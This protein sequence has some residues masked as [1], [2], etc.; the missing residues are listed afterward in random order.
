MGFN[1]AL[2]VLCD[3]LDEIERDPEFGKKVAAAIREHGS[4]AKYRRT[5]ITGQTQ[6]ISVDHADARQIIE[7]GGNTG[8]IV[9][10]GL[11]RNEKGNLE[12][13]FEPEPKKDET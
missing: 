5:Y 10:Y 1:A 4:P 2:I 12:V 9:G 11:H 7:V 6:V 3:R 13:I 8:S